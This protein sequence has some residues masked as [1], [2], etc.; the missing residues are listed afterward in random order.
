MSSIIIE[1]NDYIDLKKT[2][3]LTMKEH[4]DKIMLVRSGESKTSQGDTMA[5]FEPLI[6][7]FSIQQKTFCSKLLGISTNE[8]DNLKEDKL[9]ELY[10]MLCDIEASIPFEG[11]TKLTDEEEVASDLVTIMGAAIA[12]ELGENLTDDEFAEIINSYN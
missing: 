12:K 9:D 4:F 7:D 10:D 8:F 11:N 2:T 5:L 6:K 3:S 1:L